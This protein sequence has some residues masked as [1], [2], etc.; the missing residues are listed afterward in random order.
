MREIIEQRIREKE[1]AIQVVL[2][3]WN[4]TKQYGD[5][6]GDPKVLEYLGELCREQDQLRHQLDALA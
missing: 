5:R 3:M 4:C 2:A 1:N 6:I